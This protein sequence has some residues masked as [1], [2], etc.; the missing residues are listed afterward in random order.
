MLLQKT[1]ELEDMKNKIADE[2]IIEKVS[3][4]RK[5]LRLE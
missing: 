4:S 5:K 2:N 3:K 1:S